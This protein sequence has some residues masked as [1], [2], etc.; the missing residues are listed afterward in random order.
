[1]DDEGLLGKAI[2]LNSTLLVQDTNVYDMQNLLAFERSVVVAPLMA[3]GES[4]ESEVLGWL[5]VGA[6][7][8]NACSEE[9][10]NLVETVSYQTAMAL[11][12]ARLYEQTQQMALTDGL[13][14]LYTHRL[15][16]V[17]LSD[18]IEWAERHHKPFCLVMVDTD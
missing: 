2:E 10:R 5:Y 3:R 17:R 15:F 7:R 8:E 14:G 11:K 9:H 6:S 18:E 4:D 1:R 13:T 16:Q 12:N